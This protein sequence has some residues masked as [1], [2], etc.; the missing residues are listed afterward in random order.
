MTDKERMATEALERFH[1]VPQQ[2]ADSVSSTMHG[3]YY[4]SS[5]AAYYLL[6]TMPQIIATFAGLYVAC[7]IFRGQLLDQKSREP[8]MQ[9]GLIDRLKKGVR[10]A[11]VY[12]IVLSLI[13]IV[14]DYL[15]IFYIP[16]D[17]GLSSSSFYTLL[18]INIL[19]LSVILY[20]T[21]INLTNTKSNKK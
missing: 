5:E 11:T 10:N 3:S 2:V 15:A 13:A 4:C 12:V 8:L 18:I 6:S 7:A 9:G 1:R 19:P 21:F 16:N 17:K 20:G 14:V